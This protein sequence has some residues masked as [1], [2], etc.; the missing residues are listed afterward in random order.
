MKSLKDNIQREREF[1]PHALCKCG[2]TSTALHNILPGVKRMTAMRRIFS[3]KFPR[4]DIESLF[5]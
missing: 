2:L 5:K 4:K 1:K 3:L